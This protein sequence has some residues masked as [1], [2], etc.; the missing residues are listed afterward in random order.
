MKL[1]SVLLL[2]S[3][4]LTVEVRRKVFSNLTSLTSERLFIMAPQQDTMTRLRTSSTT[5][6]KTFEF[7]DH[8]SSVDR[9][10]FVHFCFFRPW[11]LAHAH[12]RSQ[13]HQLVPMHAKEKKQTSI[14]SLL[15]PIIGVFGAALS[16]WMKDIIQCARPGFGHRSST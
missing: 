11:A 10:W 12:G 15:T 16:F 3:N 8:R 7:H 5:L 4:W 6:P 1:S 2:G 14:S 9:T 13:P